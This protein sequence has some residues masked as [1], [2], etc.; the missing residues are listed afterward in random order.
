MEAFTRERQ[1][2]TRPR[3]VTVG[4]KYRATVIGGLRRAQEGTRTQDWVQK[5]IQFYS[6]ILSP[7]EKSSDTS[8][9]FAVGSD[10]R[11]KQ[12]Q[13]SQLT[14]C[15]ETVEPQGAIAILSSGRVFFTGVSVP[16]LPGSIRCYKA[17]LTG[18]YG[19]HT[20]HAGEQER[21]PETCEEFQ[22]KLK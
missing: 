9:L 19:K 2:E 22:R 12:I 6:V 14:G 16:G 21:R 20:C 15:Y 13:Q 8:E 17:P 4:F 11:I 5:N 10:G 3:N 7:L 1:L 18:E